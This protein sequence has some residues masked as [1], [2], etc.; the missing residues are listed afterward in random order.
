[1]AQQ[2]TITLIDDLDGSEADEQ[3]EF[4][5]DGR[6]FEID[7]SA[8]NA[9]RLRE[10]LAPFVA[11]ARRAGGR[12]GSAPAAASSNGSS[13]SER[14]AN[15]AVREWAIAQGMKISERGRIPSSVLQAYQ[16]AH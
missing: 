1:M 8:A 14:A 11:A 16:N 6:A 10:S 13:A 12:R 3:V 9:E 15:R 4:A 5:V 2:T 7:L